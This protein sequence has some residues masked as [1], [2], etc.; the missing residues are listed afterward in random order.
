[1][2]LKMC[3]CGN[4]C[5]NLKTMDEKTVFK[6]V[7]LTIPSEKYVCPH[8][9]LESGTIR[10]AAAI[11]TCIA[12]SYRLKTGLLSGKEIQRLRVAAG[13]T[14]E[15]LSSLAGVSLREIRGWETC[16]VQS[17]SVDKNLRMILKERGS[18]EIV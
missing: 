18:Y 5:M 15:Q 7:D 9:G 10:Q 17:R 16:M 2:K 14:R 12:D 8:C 6:G 1:M 4:G 13:L 11:Q 3:P